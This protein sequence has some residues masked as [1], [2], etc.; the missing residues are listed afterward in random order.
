LKFKKKKHVI[1][2]AYLSCRMVSMCQGEKIGTI[3]AKENPNNI[4]LLY[5]TYGVH[6]TIFLAPPLVP[7]IQGSIF[8]PKKEN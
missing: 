4:F 2:Q 5:S 1:G 6:L 7:F 3:L 8:L